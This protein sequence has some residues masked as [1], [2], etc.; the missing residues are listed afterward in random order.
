MRLIML[1]I[2]PITA[3]NA[4]LLLFRSRRA[5]VALLGCGSK[6]LLHLAGPALGIKKMPDILEDLTEIVGGIGGNLLSSQIEERLKA[7]PADQLTLCNQHLVKF[8]G[9]V[10]QA[11]VEGALSEPQLALHDID[12]RKGLDELPQKWADFVESGVDEAQPLSTQDFVQT[13]SSALRG[14][15]DVPAV[16]LE[17]LQ[18]FFAVWLQQCVGK[19]YITDGLHLTLAGLIGPRIGAGIAASLPEQHP[20]AEAAFKKSLLRY[21]SQTESYL[22]IAQRHHDWNRE[23]LIGMEAMLTGLQQSTSHIATVQRRESEKAERIDRTTTEIKADSTN[24]KDALTDVKDDTTEIKAKAAALCDA[25]IAPP[26]DLLSKLDSYARTVLEKLSPVPLTQILNQPD[27]PVVSV[28]R[29]YTPLQ[30]RHVSYKDI[31]RL[32]HA[33]ELSD[34]HGR[35]TEHDAPEELKQHQADLADFLRTSQPRDAMD[36]LDNENF[37]HHVFLGEPGGGKT[38]FARHIVTGWAETWPSLRDDWRS[39]WISIYVE[40]KHYAQLREDHA[41]TSVRDYLS[42][43]HYPYGALP[44]IIF[45]E[46]GTDPMFLLIFDG[47]DEVLH[48]PTKSLIVE[49]LIGLQEMRH[50]VIVTSR[51]A[52][53][54]PQ[55]WS[56]YPWC[57]IYRI[58]PL[59][60]T[61]QRSFIQLYHEAFFPNQ[62]ERQFRIDR[63]QH[64]LRDFHRLAEL[65]GTPLL[66]TLLC[67]VNR[68]PALPE[69]RTEL[70][71]QAAEL[72]LHNWDFFHFQQDDHQHRDHLAPLQ[73]TE[74]H[75]I[76]RRLAWLLMMGKPGKHAN[77]S[78]ILCERQHLSANLFPTSI[79]ADAVR[80]V[81]KELNKPNPENYVAL[82]PKLL[83][84]RN[85]VLCPST[86]G[87][88]SFIHRTFLE[89]YAAWAWVEEEIPWNDPTVPWADNLWPAA[90]T[91]Q[92]R[93]EHLFQPHWQDS[94][95]R[96]ILILHCGRLKP[97]YAE[98]LLRSLLNLADT[99]AAA[100]GP[101]HDNEK[102]MA[103]Q[104]ESLAAILLAAEAFSETHER[105]RLPDL[106]STLQ[107]R[108][109]TLAASPL[110]TRNT[111]DD[112]YQQNLE[113]RKAAVR[114]T[115][116]LSTAPPL[117]E[118]W[119]HSLSTDTKLRDGVRE[120]SLSELAS[121]SGLSQT[122][123]QHLHDLLLHPD[124]SD[125]Y[126]NV[127]FRQFDRHWGQPGLDEALQSLAGLDKLE[128]LYLYGCTG[129]RGT[130][131]L[132]PLPA[133]R[134]LSLQGCTGLEDAGALQGLAG[135]DKLKVLDLNFCTGLRSTQGLPP[136]PALKSLYLHQ[137]T[138]LKGLQGLA[139]LPKLEF[140]YLHGCTG[141]GQQAL[142][143]LR[144]QFPS[145][146]TII[147]PDGKE[148]DA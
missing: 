136:L 4:L 13:L 22:I 81:L 26:I 77:D 93:Y 111:S 131:A 109:Q 142:A 2:E 84:E 98:K 107:Q 119:L 79:V 112:Q 122:Y 130:Q 29:V 3:G 73:K 21:H 47:L 16:P 86:V 120:A 72:L 121:L 95:W 5:I 96:I 28:D 128:E 75:A 110:T 92:Q 88:H 8:T 40:L 9:H 132:P 105:G 56:Q 37:S 64:K 51:I 25:L 124:T 102:A 140:L 59:T 103:L 118:R 27:L 91:P 87:K 76:M 83:V 108:L 50:H 35:E 69:T 133:L 100:A 36:V 85:S 15:E 74:K 106:H 116:Q 12:L 123:R 126:R 80:D 113:H 67:L 54:D 57:L 134:K 41:V 34:W 66:L 143:E 1:P 48:G 127:L 99:K 65:A 20:L 137:C 97:S 30:V 53:F 61:E 23:K 11:L 115:V 6:A 129:L 63:L 14:K 46:D 135:L 148:V 62:E 7:L 19:T 89:F 146:C 42:G 33:K 38:L 90:M 114:L 18:A 44:D 147:G 82:L 144:R 70:Y 68:D 78:G 24:I 101:D 58:D 55:P 43:P 71:E 104:L 17:H 138:G 52:D 125:G 117:T 139:G 39:Q 94:I 45:N 60:P 145:R 10:L 141:V 32:L 49:E 31:G